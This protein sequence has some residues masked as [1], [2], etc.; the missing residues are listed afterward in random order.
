[1][2]DVNPLPMNIPYPAK[3]VP[4]GFSLV[5]T[6]IVVV[7]IGIFTAMSVSALAL[8][9]DFEETKAQR[10]AQ[11]IASVH[12]AAQ[13]AGLDL[14]PS[15]SS[16]FAEGINSVVAG[17]RPVT[18]PFQGVFFGL[19]SLHATSVTETLPY[20]QFHRS[21]GILSYVPGGVTADKNLVP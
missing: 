5:E 21:Q 12:A 19:K 15:T 11:E 9:S 7:L 6:L 20:L 14:F 4:R 13:A 10:N 3:S 17:G 18:G 2:A 16:S 8:R 1:V